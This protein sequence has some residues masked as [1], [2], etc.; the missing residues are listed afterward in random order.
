MQKVEIFIYVNHFLGTTDM[1]PN[2]ITSIVHNKKIGHYHS[3]PVV[4]PVV[5]H[6]LMQSKW[7]G[8]FF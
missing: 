7:W 4:R 8:I 1:S 3:F 5:D 6:S 2:P